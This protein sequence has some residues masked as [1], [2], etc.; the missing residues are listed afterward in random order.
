MTQHIKNIE[1][2]R[3]YSI[4]HHPQMSSPTSHNNSFDRSRL[5]QI[6]NLCSTPKS[7]KSQL[8]LIPEVIRGRSQ[9]SSNL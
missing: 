9:S 7:Q 6:G 5:E 3:H 2:T 1:A 8:S 4:P